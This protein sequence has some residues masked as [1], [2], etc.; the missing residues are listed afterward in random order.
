M[1][2]FIIESKWVY[3]LIRVFVLLII[4][5]FL[6]RLS[7]SSVFLGMVIGMS[8]KLSTKIT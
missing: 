8:E 1:K 7:L 6:M 3:I 2:V 4:A 5:K